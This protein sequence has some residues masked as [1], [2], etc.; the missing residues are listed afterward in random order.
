LNNQ[1]VQAGDKGP[2]IQSE[3]LVRYKNCIDQLIVQGDAYYCFCTKE[4]LDEVR[5]IQELN[6]QPTGY[7]GNCLN[8]N[9]DDAKKRIESGEK[10]VVRLKM[11]KTGETIFTDLIRGE[12]KFKNELVDDQ[13]LLKTDG[14]PTYHLAAVVDDHDT[15]I[16]HV[17]RGDEWLSSV[18][19]H[20]MLYKMFGWQAPEFA[21][22]TLLLNA[23]KSKLSKRQG[24]V[25]VEDYKNK[26]YLPE[27]IINFIAFLGWNP[28][29]EREIFSLEE[30][31]NEFSLEKVNK[32]GAVFNLEK[33]DW[34]NKEYLKKMNNTKLAELCKPL[35]EDKFQISNFK[36]QIDKVVALEKERA[37]T[38]VELVENVR[39]VFELGDYE[40][41]LLVWK[42]SDKAKTKENLAKLSQILTKLGDFSKEKLETIIGEWLK[43][44]N[45]G[46]GDVLWPMRVALSGQKNSPGPYEIA[47]VLGR[48]ESLKRIN[49]AISKL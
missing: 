40:S 28:G 46:T 44:E 3:K 34:Y 5:K 48:E 30:L 11:P 36:F 20:L 39:F 6:K 35:L 14:F 23:D 13:V 43:A 12:V 24:D 32:A 33:L 8:I 47:E 9:L 38:L 49:L 37:T 17:L 22:L 7:D 45:L 42:K 18:P 41:E 21:H 10:F 19:K 25:S 27:A 29:D 26:G 31:V 15:E 4:R 1:I 16:T 2:Y